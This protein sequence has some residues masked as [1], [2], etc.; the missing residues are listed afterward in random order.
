MRMAVGAVVA[1]ATV[2][3]PAWAQSAGATIQAFGL[4][5]TWASDCTGDPGPHRP[6]FKM[7]VAMPGKGPPTRTTVSSDGANTTTVNAEIVGASQLG[8]TGLVIEAKITEGDRDGGPLPAI[9][10]LDFDQSFEKLEPNVLY[11]KGRDPVRLER[12]PIR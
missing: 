2:V 12:C 7:T 10:L 3:G 5:G 6:G 8:T 1:L 4:V 9:A 11:I